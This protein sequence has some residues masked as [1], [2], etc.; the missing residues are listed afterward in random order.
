MGTLLA[1]D[2]DG[3]I[4]DSRPEC[5]ITGLS[6]YSRIDLELGKPTRNINALDPDIVS[7]F[8]DHRHLV[9]VAKE[10]VLLF[11][12]LLSNQAIRD[13]VPLQEQTQADPDRLK[14]YKF[15]FY[16]ER[17]AWF[18]E[19][20]DSWLAHNEIF[21]EVLNVSKLWCGLERLA[22]VSAKD[23]QSIRT[24]LGR[25]GLHLNSASILDTN[26]GD[27]PEHLQALTRKYSKIF[28]V[29]DHLENLLNIGTNAVIPLMA[30]W[31]FVSRHSLESARNNG[32]E[33][34][35]LSR[36]LEYFS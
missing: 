34:L 16:S 13:D 7:R 31:G 30:S 20:P 19:D 28:F 5:L 4:C 10:F 29:D 15:Y 33:V 2:F 36:F 11:D 25:K 21:E 6:A 23:E 22:I 35:D 8:M 3:V 27:K 17:D 14:L 9:R 18:Q 1:L 12:L 24:I 26:K 32:I